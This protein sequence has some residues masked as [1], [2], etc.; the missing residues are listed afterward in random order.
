VSKTCNRES[1]KTPC[2]RAKASSEWPLLGQ[3]KSIFTAEDA[4]SAEARHLI[5]WYYRF[6]GL[7]K[8]K[9]PMNTDEHR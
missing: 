9:P 1:R 5:P 4:E 7:K 2:G 6:N 3:W 8:L